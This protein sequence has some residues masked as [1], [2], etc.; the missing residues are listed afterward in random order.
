MRIVLISLALF[1][2]WLPPGLCA[3]GLQAALFP[4]SADEPGDDDHDDSHECHCAGVK[5]LCVLLAREHVDHGNLSLA[6]CLPPV[7]QDHV[8]GAETLN[9]PPCPFGH[10]SLQPLYLTLRALRI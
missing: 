1:Y 2:A 3:C 8:G 6:A 9:P 7:N 5:P 4:R 10:G